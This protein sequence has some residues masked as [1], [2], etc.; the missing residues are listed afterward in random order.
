[1][2]KHGTYLVGTDF[3]AAHLET[4]GFPGSD[5]Y[6]AM[7]IARLKL[8]HEVGVKLAFGTDVVIDLKGVDRAQMALDYLAVWEEAG[9]PAPEILRSMTTE[10]A[11]L[12]GISGKRGSIAEGQKADIVATP[13]NPLVDIQAL[14]DIQFVMKNGDVVRSPVAAVSAPAAEATESD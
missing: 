7:I 12:L 10:V 13:E 9:V 11:E 1:M 5:R 3:P 6:G 14:R 8:A 2:K 4:I